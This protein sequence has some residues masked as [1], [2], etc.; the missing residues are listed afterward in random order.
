MVNILI[1]KG[2]SNTIFHTLEYW[3]YN[4]YTLVVAFFSCYHINALDCLTVQGG[5]MYFLITLAILYAIYR[6]NKTYNYLS[7]KMFTLMFISGLCVVFLLASLPIVRPYNNVKTIY[8]TLG[9]FDLHRHVSPYIS[10]DTHLMLISLFSALLIVFTFGF[11]SE[12]IHTQPKL[13]RSTHYFLLFLYPLLSLITANPIIYKYICSFKWYG[14]YYTSLEV[15][16]L[17]DF[18]NDALKLIGL[19]LMFFCTTKLLN[20]YLQQP[21][22]I[23]WK[24]NALYKLL[25]II[26]TLLIFLAVVRWTPHR[27]IDISSSGYFQYLLTQIEGKAT[28]SVLLLYSLPIIFFYEFLIINQLK[29]KV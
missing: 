18:F 5:R 27:L 4:L 9:L 8:S 13:K 10:L 3:G 2:Y 17:I 19:C 20:N 11:A 25:T 7:I 21:N 22:V 23:T 26:P 6:I 29:K 28:L 24:K 14:I 1:L 16:M 12:V 15:N